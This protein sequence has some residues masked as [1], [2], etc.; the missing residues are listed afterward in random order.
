MYSLLRCLA[1]GTG[2]GKA[3]KQKYKENAVRKI[4]ITDIHA[5]VERRGP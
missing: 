5:Y 4:T 1:P 3:E 2:A